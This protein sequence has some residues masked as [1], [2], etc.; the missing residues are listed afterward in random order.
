MRKRSQIEQNPGTKSQLKETTKMNETMCRYADESKRVSSSNTRVNRPNAPMQLPVNTARP[1]ADN[2]LSRI[3]P[4]PRMMRRASTGYTT[5]N[6]RTK[7]RRQSG[8]AV[9]DILAPDDFLRRHES[10]LERTD[11]IKLVKQYQPEDI[12]KKPNKVKEPAR[13]RRRKPRRMSGCAMSAKAISSD[14]PCLLERE[15]SVRLT[16]Q[17]LPSRRASM[18]H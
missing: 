13:I 8:L 18:T 17:R 4:G 9:E 15:N 12:I 16:K 3:V 14:L 6:H 11:S 2:S 1:M 5:A 7:A 10:S